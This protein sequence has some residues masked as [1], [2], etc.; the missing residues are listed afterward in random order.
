M[1]RY[2]H[3]LVLAV[4]LGCVNTIDMPT[5]QSFMIEM[6]GREDLLNAIALNSSVFNVARIIGPAVG[7]IMMGLLGTAFCFFLN[8]LSF[9]AVI[10]GLLLIKTVPFVRKESRQKNV[11]KDIKEG[12]VYT[13]KNPV[14]LVTLV[15]LM[16]VNIFVMNFNVTIPV[17]VKNALN[18]EETSYGFLMS[19][20]G[21]GSFIGAIFIASKS[22][23]SPNRK[24]MFA[25]ALVSSFMLAIL[26]LIH[27]FYLSMPILALVGFFNI[28]FTAM[29]NSTVQLNTADEYRGRVMSLY[30]MM[31]AGTTPFG[32]LIAGSLADVLG[33]SWGF[34]IS[35]AASLLIVAI[36]IILRKR[37]EN[38]AF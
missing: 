11:F 19:V 36:L 25:C 10:I 22:K 8:G 7:G 33:P 4:L 14:V 13:R 24:I 16:V 20:M 28:S 23:F 32:N 34:I 21:A 15:V 6:V 35:G 5:R 38:I 17:F 12:L 30:T 37:R 3:I 29:G 27:N 1:I 26:G 31:F 18:L 2:W 9:I